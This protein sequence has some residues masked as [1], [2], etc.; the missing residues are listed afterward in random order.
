M[1]PT[2]GRSATSTTRCST[3]GTAATPFDWMYA[4][5]GRPSIPPERLPKASR[6][7]APYS[8]RSERAFRERLEYDPL[9]RWFPGM[10][11]VEPGFD[12]S[13]L[14]KNRA[15]LMADR[16][17][18]EFFDAVAWQAQRR[19]LLSEEHVTVDGTLLE[20]AA[21]PKSFTRRGE[22]DPPADARAPPRRAIP[23]QPPARVIPPLRGLLQRP[24]AL[25]CQSPSTGHRRSL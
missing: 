21:S 12:H 11:L 16:V 4:E 7:M 22:G 25:V 23:P 1:Q 8:V 17:A 13:T 5:V 19:R 15:R 6:L 24:D 14:S 2:C 18:R 10:D 20:A 3:P 9:F